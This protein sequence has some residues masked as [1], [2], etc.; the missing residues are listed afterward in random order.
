MRIGFIGLGHMGQGIAANLLKAGH[1]LTVWNRSPEATREL[2]AQG[3][4]VA[5]SPAGA[6]GGE[7]L[8]S[9]LADDAASRAVLLAG[10]TFD[11]ARE[12][13]VHVSL[14]TLSLAF[15][16]ELEAHHRQAG[17]GLLSAPV[18]GR[19]DAAAAGKLNIVV[20]GDP[21]SLEKVQPLLDA[22][23]QKTWP[24]GDTPTQANVVKLA[25]NFMIASAIETMGE[26]SA[27]V[28]GH[29]VEPA[30]LLE[31]LGSTLFAAPVY[32]N[33]G[34]QLIERR[35]EPAGFKLRLGLKDVNLA[36]AAGQARHVP[37]PFASVLR[38]NLT[39]AVAQGQGE[40][41]WV[42]LGQRAQTRAGQD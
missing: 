17:I 22:I 35:F 3:A 12:G 21:A 8:F 9:M 31:I 38:D 33:Y 14:A 24:V 2:A 37:L 6:A 20:A 41:D 36:L 26:A 28:R 13:L 19:P 34:K 18:F 4:S 29:G 16:E 39:E 15:V 25:G 40:H 23:G 1:T 10:G 11:G 5:D 42:A 30:R 27:L 7:V 32:Q